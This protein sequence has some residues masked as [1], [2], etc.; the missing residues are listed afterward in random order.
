MA[1]LAVAGELFLL[2]LVAAVLVATSLA[3]E[4]QLQ[5]KMETGDGSLCVWFELRKG[6]SRGN[7]FVSACHCKDAEGHRHSYSCEYDGP[8]EDCEEYQHSPKEFYD[9]IAS[10]LQSM[11]LRHMQA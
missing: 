11:L 6:G 8:M 10:S 9:I 5:G 1:H 4:Q 3:E 7:V 2:F